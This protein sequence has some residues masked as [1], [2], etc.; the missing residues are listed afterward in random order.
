[1]VGAFSYQMLDDD[2]PSKYGYR[3]EATR[4]R[5]ARIVSLPEEDTR[6]SRGYRTGRGNFFLSWSVPSPTRCWTMTCPRNMDTVR[7]QREQDPRGL[8]RF[9]KRIPEE[10]ED[11]GQGEETFSCHGRCLLLPDA[12][13]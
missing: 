9:Q 4:T 8:Y 11:T 12:G 6:R 5:S 7:R 10:V 3:Q 1:M 13:R 2:L